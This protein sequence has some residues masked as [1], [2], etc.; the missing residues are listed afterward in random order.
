[1]NSS[2]DY[3]GTKHFSYNVIID[4]V[5]L[6]VVDCCRRRRCRRYSH[7]AEPEVGR[8]VGGDRVK[9][10]GEARTFNYVFFSFL[11]KLLELA[12]LVNEK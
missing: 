12:K 9:D 11:L 5:V 2:D 8:V 4:G 7:R 1:M 3:S 10:G 6:K